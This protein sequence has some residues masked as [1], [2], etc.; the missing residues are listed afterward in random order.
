M[1]KLDLA[2]SRFSAMLRQNDPK[3]LF[4]IFVRVTKPRYFTVCTS[5][6][7]HKILCLN[8]TQQAENALPCPDLFICL[9]YSQLAPPVSHIRRHGEGNIAGRPWRMDP[10]RVV[11]WS[12]CLQPLDGPPLLSVEALTG[13]L[14]FNL[15]CHGRSALP[16]TFP[17]P[18]SC[19]SAPYMGASWRC[20]RWAC[21]FRAGRRFEPQC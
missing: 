3:N 5:H 11:H 8:W 7:H 12:Y 16:I 14:L 2:I 20:R 15:P 18:A 19:R 17:R 9:P 21:S 10:S 13:V 1:A 4:D 6:I